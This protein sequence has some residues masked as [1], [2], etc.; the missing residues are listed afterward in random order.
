MK[1][2]KTSKIFTALVLLLFLY[3]FSYADFMDYLINPKLIAQSEL[4]LNELNVKA[5][6]DFTA[7]FESVNGIGSDDKTIFVSGNN[8][9]FALEYLR[10][11]NVY[12]AAGAGVG[13]Q[14][15][16]RAKYFSGDFDFIPVYLTAKIRSWP[17]EPGLFGYLVG[18]VGYSEFY[19]SSEFEKDFKVKN[20]G[21][22][23]GGGFGV[24]YKSVIFEFLYSVNNCEIEDNVSKSSIG[25]TYR[26]WTFSVGYNFGDLF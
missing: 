15:P 19:A 14:L 23:Y 4:G 12:L 17:Q 21:V 26:R 22:Y 5:G 20:G 16:R 6:Y 7:Y 1:K 10:Y 9:S 2:N 8:L 18:Q 13:A 25:L 24:S 11:I 3:G